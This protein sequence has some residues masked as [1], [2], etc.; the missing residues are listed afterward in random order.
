MTLHMQDKPPRDPD[1]PDPGRRRF[2]RGLAAPALLGTL[3]SQPVLGQSLYHCT[4]SGQ[5]SGNISHRSTFECGSLGMSPEEWIAKADWTP[6]D[7]GDLPSKTGGN[8]CKFTGGSAAGDTFNSVFGGNYYFAVASGSGS[9][10]NCAILTA[11]GTGSN[12]HHASM[13]EVLEWS[14][15]ELGRE[16]VVA[17]LNASQPGD[18]GFP[19]TPQRVVHMFKDIATTG[20]YYPMSSSMHGWDRDTVIAYWK[21]LYDAP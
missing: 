3:A 2:T 17:L 16:A 20:T 12:D 19:I 9:G 11:A 14:T 18:Q 5:W 1:R 7:K 15:D 4:P 13:R 6:Y 10:K 21:S 8:S